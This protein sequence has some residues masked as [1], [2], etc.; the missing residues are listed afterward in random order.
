M[1]KGS[2]FRAF[3]VYK[4]LGFIGFRGLTG[5]MGF[6]GRLG[7]IGFMGFLGL[8]GFIE[9][10]PQKAL[11]EPCHPAS[12]I[13]KPSCMEITRKVQRRSLDVQ[14]LKV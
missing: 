2:G 5:F 7:L 4:G 13:A 9:F 12:S 3:R 6:L 11:W 8:M 1:Y 14:T 10:R